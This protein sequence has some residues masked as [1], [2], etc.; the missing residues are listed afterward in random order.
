MILDLRLQLYFLQYL[1]LVLSA[2]LLFSSLIVFSSLFV[3][4]KREIVRTTPAFR[5]LQYCK[6][7]KAALRHRNNNSSYVI[8][9]VFFHRARNE[10]YPCRLLTSFLS[11]TQKLHGEPRSLTHLFMH[12]IT[13][14]YPTSNNKTSHLHTC[15]IVN[16]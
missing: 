11:D 14:A 5:H 6:Q 13:H 3:I 2:Q 12:S 10:F 16:H 9:C 1:S 7:R 4:E 8:F 15:M